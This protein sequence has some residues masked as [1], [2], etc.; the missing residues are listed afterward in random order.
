VAGMAR[1]LRVEVEDGHLKFLT[2]LIKQKARS[3]FY[4]DGKLAY[5]KDLVEKKYQ[6]EIAQWQA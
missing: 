1:N 5:A 2:L 4:R 3:A 6:D